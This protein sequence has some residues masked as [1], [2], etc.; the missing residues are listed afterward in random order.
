MSHALYHFLINTDEDYQTVGSAAEGQFSDYVEERF[1]DNNW[2]TPLALAVKDGPVDISDTDYRGGFDSWV[3]K[4]DRERW[5]FDFAVEYAYKCM[6]AEINQNINTVTN[7]DYNTKREFDSPEAA[8]MA[9]AEALASSYL[10]DLSGVDRGEESWR[11]YCR[12]KLAKVYEQLTDKYFEPPFF[13]AWEFTPYNARAFDL[14]DGEDYGLA[15]L[16]V[17]VHT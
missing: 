9:I 7:S 1:D 14:T 6:Y 5:D 4:E 16:T 2:F 8:A 12:P 10:R 15:I 13:N 17:D 11:T 3:T